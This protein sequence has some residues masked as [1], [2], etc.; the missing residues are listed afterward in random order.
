MC[1]T[2]SGLEAG[3]AQVSE[4]DRLSSD[5]Y[6]E[7]CILFADMSCESPKLVLWSQAVNSTLTWSKWSHWQLFRGAPHMYRH[8]SQYSYHSLIKTKGETTI[9]GLCVKWKNKHRPRFRAG[10]CSKMYV[11]ERRYG[12]EKNC[13]AVFKFLIFMLWGEAVSSKSQT[14]FMS[15]PVVSNNSSILSPLSCSLCCEI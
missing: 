8:D 1:R 3:K 4:T 10:N 6:L 7:S 15:L 13:T 9:C 14:G 11:G 5:C 2:L 12:G